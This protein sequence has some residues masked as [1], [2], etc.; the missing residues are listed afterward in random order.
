MYLVVFFSCAFCSGPSPGA[1]CVRESFGA[2]TEPRL[3]RS[4]FS[5]LTAGDIKMTVTLGKTSIF[6]NN[7]ESFHD[8]AFVKIRK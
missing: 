6:E 1:I 2:F 5:D 3:V 7:H 4:E 8:L